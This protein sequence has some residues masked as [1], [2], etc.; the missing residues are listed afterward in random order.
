[1]TVLLFLLNFTYS[2]NAVTLNYLVAGHDQ[3][4]VSHE[5]QSFYSLSAKSN[6]LSL[7]IHEP[8]FMGKIKKD[9][10]LI[11][12]AELK[13]LKPFIVKDCLKEDH[14]YLLAGDIYNNKD[15]Y[16]EGVVVGVPNDYQTFSRIYL[17]SIKR[18]H[19]YEPTEPQP[20][21]GNFTLGYAEVKGLLLIYS[22][23]FRLNKKLISIDE[24]L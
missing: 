24:L 23:A 7:S 19:G 3:S 6:S 1:M 16:F 14:K 10:S 15:Y 22:D 2:I 21:L 5:R 17:C 13:N 11:D 20:D 18:N 9:Y 8:L 12:R 4:D